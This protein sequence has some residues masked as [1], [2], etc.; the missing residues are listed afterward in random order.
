MEVLPAVTADAVHLAAVIDL[1]AARLKAALP[2]VVSRCM[3]FSAVPDFDASLVGA[4]QAFYGIDVDVATA[5]T[6]I[7]EDDL[8]RVRF[9]PWFLWDWTV[10][11]ENVTVG[12]RF[13][14]TGELGADEGRIL[15]GLNASCVWFW[16]VRS[17]VTSGVAGVE[18][19]EM[20]GDSTIWV[21]D[22]ALASGV[23]AGDVIQARIV[24]IAGSRGTV[25]H[26]LDAVYVCLPAMLRDAL[27]GRLRGIVDPGEGSP[28]YLQKKRI[29]PELIELAEDIVESELKQESELAEPLLLCT[30]RVGPGAEDRIRDHFV[31][32]ADG[33]GWRVDGPDGNVLGVLEARTQGPS[34]CHAIGRQHFEALRR[35]LADVGVMVAPMHAETAFEPVV[36]AWLERAAVPAWAEHLPEGADILRKTVSEWSLLWP[37]LVHPSL[38]RRPRDVLDD[39]DGR[40]DV[41]RL[42]DRMQ[43]G[44]PDAFTSPVTA[45]R[46]RLGVMAMAE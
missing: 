46:E 43:R 42:L 33:V 28:D 12:A 39:V 44:L 10:P 5:E 25:V 18:L 30:S 45:L 3:A 20:L 23:G 29:A 19:A 2:R 37:E 22:A 11:G 26:V 15:A 17:V 38:G 36:A 8:E 4:V 27:E 1:E 32:L 9:F 7:L 24:S 13:A 40:R 35:S 21:Q 41:A 14:E 34:R 6:D 31:A 16:E